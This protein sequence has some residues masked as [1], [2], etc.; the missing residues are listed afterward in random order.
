VTV[1]LGPTR[2]KAFSDADG[3]NSASNRCDISSEAIG[4]TRGQ[5]C[6][7]CCTFQMLLGKRSG[8]LALARVTAEIPG[9]E[10]DTWFD[11]CPGRGAKSKEARCRYRPPCHFKP[12]PSFRSEIADR[13]ETDSQKNL[14]EKNINSHNLFK[15]LKYW[16]RGRDSNPRDGSSP[17]TRSPGVRLQPLGHPSWVGRD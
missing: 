16:R 12:R 10:Q 9:A 15:S 14:W 5:P 13:E 3:A 17:S 11:M 1:T 6:L 8:D 2:R 7:N 4:Y